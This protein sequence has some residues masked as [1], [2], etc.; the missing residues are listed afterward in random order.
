MFPFELEAYWEW[1]KKAPSRLLVLDECHSST[2]GRAINRMGRLKGLLYHL[3][4]VDHMVESASINNSHSFKNDKLR[5]TVSLCRS[6]SAIHISK[7][8]H[9]RY[10][11]NH[12]ITGIRY[13]NNVVCEYEILSRKNKNGCG[14]SF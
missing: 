12:K 6:E 1:G 14:N 10:A 2:R 7:V 9:H 8:K 3:P 5:Q 4:L 13:V 11:A